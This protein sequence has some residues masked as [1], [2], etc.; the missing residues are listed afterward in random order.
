MLGSQWA[1]ALGGVLIAGACILT[2]RVMY[3]LDASFNA[4]NGGPPGWNIAMAFTLLGFTILLVS[5]VLMLWGSAEVLGWLGFY[6]ILAFSLVPRMFDGP[7][8]TMW[9]LIPGHF[10]LPAIALGTL[11]AAAI[12]YLL[13]RTAG[14]QDP[15]RASP[16]PQRT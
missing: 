11:G 13:G 9:T 8:D 15:I 6:G 3:R 1:R 4:W 10:P 2:P 12:G 5:G 16:D 14:R 7:R